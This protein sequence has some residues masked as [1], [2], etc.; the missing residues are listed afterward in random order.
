MEPKLKTTG[1]LGLSTWRRNNAEP[2]RTI[3]T[4]YTDHSGSGLEQFGSTTSTHKRLSP[5]SL[6]P[7]L[8]GSKCLFSWREPLRWSK[9]KESSVLPDG[10]VIEGK[11]NVPTNMLKR[12][13]GDIQRKSMCNM[14]DFFFES[15]RSDSKRDIEG[16]TKSKVTHSMDGGTKNS[17]RKS[18]PNSRLGKISLSCPT[19]NSN[20]NWRE[21][22]SPLPSEEET[23]D[24][25]RQL[26]RIV[27]QSPKKVKTSQ[28]GEDVTTD[29][30]SLNAGKKKTL[31][32][33]WISSHVA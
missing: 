17:Q 10:S 11:E 16:N 2:V 29:G 27:Q 31:T 25:W 30:T 23:E 19:R 15:A 22:M 1:I 6:R 33:S 26:Q 18:Y 9:P 5:T 21:T 7:F 4:S 24:S 12:V 13:P 3:K 28:E 14:G 8:N 32:D 20:C